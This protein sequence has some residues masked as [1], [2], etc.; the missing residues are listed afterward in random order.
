M[1]TAIRKNE[2]DGWN[3]LNIFYADDPTTDSWISHPMNPIT[4]NI[5]NLRPA[6]SIFVENNQI[7][8]P[9]QISSP[10]EY[11]KAI[12]I[13]KINIL[14]ERNYNEEMI[15]KIEPWEKDIKG[16]HTLNHENGLTVFDSKW[17]IRKY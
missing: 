1:F 4:N 11:G 14:D 9:A 8:R 5:E 7:Y 15:K 6:G 12:A 13:N 17:K 10:N 3:N 16:I 2:K